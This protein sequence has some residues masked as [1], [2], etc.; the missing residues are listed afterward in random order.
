MIICYFSK[1]VEEVAAGVAAMTVVDP[2]EIANS[3]GAPSSLAKTAGHVNSR[4]TKKTLVFQHHRAPNYLEGWNGTTLYSPALS[5]LVERMDEFQ[6]E[7]SD[8]LFAFKM[9]ASMSSAFGEEKE[10]RD[11]FNDLLI[12][13]LA[14]EVTPRIISRQS[15][16]DITTDGSLV[17][18]FGRHSALLLQTEDKVER[19]HA[20]CPE[21]ENLAYYLYFILGQ[22]EV[23]NKTCCPV[24]FL[25]LEGNLLTLSIGAFEGEMVM[26]DTVFSAVLEVSTVHKRLMERQAAIWHA[27]RKGVEE[28]KAEYGQLLQSRPGKKIEAS[29]LFAF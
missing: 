22:P 7:P 11:T 18:L 6:F 1:P 20:G 15:E 4:P 27:V 5:R 14:S 3:L 16:K 21:A 25:E 24:I 26:K 28:L 10:R 13:L 2:R 17:Q 12:E 29:V 19:G 9:A 8:L 23:Y